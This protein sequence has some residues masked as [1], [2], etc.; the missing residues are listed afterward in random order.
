MAEKLSAWAPVAL[1]SPDMQHATCQAPVTLMATCMQAQAA[2]ATAEALLAFL[3][4]QYE[5]PLSPQL[6]TMLFRLLSACGTVVLGPAASVLY[7]L[8]QLAQR[9]YWPW[10]LHQTVARLLLES[11]ISIMSAACAVMRQLSAWSVDGAL[12]RPAQA[13]LAT[14]CKPATMHSFWAKCVTLVDHCQD[15]LGGRCMC[16][17][18]VACSQFLQGLGNDWWCMP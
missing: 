2:A 7:C 17:A 4:A 13:A 3:P 1:A 18:I 6:S 9:S 10:W 8:Q 15:W 5:G 16:T 11:C 12:S 14:T